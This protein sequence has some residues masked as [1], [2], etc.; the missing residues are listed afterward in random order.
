M[1]R[2][3]GKVQAAI[4]QALQ[5]LA[6]AQV[7]DGNLHPRVL[8]PKGQD[9]FIDAIEHRRQRRNPDR[10]G[11]QRRIL[12]ARRFDLQAAYALYHEV[13]M[14]DD[15]LAFLGKGHAFVR[16]LQ[17]GKPH[18]PLQLLDRTAQRGLSN[19]HELG[20]FEDAACVMNGDQR[21]ELVK[22]QPSVPCC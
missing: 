7:G 4:A 12:N 8:A 10:H 5:D 20:G 1:L 13:G 9:T 2:S 14:A 6:G 19:V 22:F 15:T 3:N 17:Q 18:L 11:A 21:P 16:P